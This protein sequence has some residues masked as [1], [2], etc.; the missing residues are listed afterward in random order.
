[1][2]ETHRVTP[3]PARALRAWQSDAFAR[4][5]RAQPRDFLTVATPGAGKTTLALTIAADLLH[6]NVVE[7]IVVVAPTD[8]L[9]TQWAHA[10][11]RMGISLDP[12]MAG[13]RLIPIRSAAW[14]HCVLRWSVGAT[15]TMRSTTFR[16][17]KSAAIVRA[18]VVLPAPGVATV[19]KSRGWAR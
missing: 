19:R 4:Y 5:Q 17:N 13:S 10:A 15:T 18:K 2:V 11:E 16:C 6:R 3:S 9:K 12:A 7:R 14:A 8:H 1:M